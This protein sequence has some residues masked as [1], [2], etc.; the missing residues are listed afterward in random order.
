MDSRS[1]LGVQQ[2]R[3]PF[4]DDLSAAESA[5]NPSQPPSRPHDRDLSI[6]HEMSRRY[7]SKTTVDDERR[8][9]RRLDEDEDDDDEDDD[10]DEEEEETW[11][12]AGG[13][14]C[15]AKGQLLLDFG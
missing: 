10:E 2:L 12:V 3:P 7:V 13:R 15:S 6:R 8:R 9:R 14:S 4:L 5:P 11:Q 1:I